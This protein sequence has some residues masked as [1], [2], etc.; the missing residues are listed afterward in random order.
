MAAQGISLVYG[1]A[2][3]GIMGA[4]ADRLMA[5]GGQAVGVIPEALVEMEVA[6]Q[7]LT[8]LHV[9]ADMHERKARMAELSDG[10]VS[11][12]GGLGTLEEM[13]EMLTWAQLGMHSKPCGI[14]NVAGFYDGLLS[15]LDNACKE[16][17]MLQAHR[18]LL[19]AETEPT[20]LLARMKA[21]EAQTVSKLDWRKLQ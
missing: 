21:Y 19:I 17:F 2:H 14:L 6:H 8:E 3:V 5:L 11:L 13:F 7:G 9:V 1:G 20:A 15:F 4:V 18:D 10:F 12:P 16:A